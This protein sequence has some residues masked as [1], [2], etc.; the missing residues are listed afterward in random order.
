[1]YSIRKPTPTIAVFG[2][3]NINY[4]PDMYIKLINLYCAM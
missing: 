3:S 1:M 2:Y 4:K